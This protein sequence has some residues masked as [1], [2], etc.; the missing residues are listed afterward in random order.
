MVVVNWT[1]WS[2][3]RLRLLNPVVGI[4]PLVR[5]FRREIHVPER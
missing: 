2:M 4:A 3:K 1:V 5:L